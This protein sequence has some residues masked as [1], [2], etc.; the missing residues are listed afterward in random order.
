MWV[1]WLDTGAVRSGLSRA[2]W[3]AEVEDITAWAADNRPP[4][5]MHGL[6][7]G[8]WK[9]GILPRTRRRT[10]PWETAG[11]STASPTYR[12]ITL[13][14]R[15]PTLYSAF[16]RSA[17]YRLLARINIFLMRGLRKEH[18]RLPTYKMA[19][20]GWCAWFREGREVRLLPATR[21]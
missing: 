20:A 12:Q 9:W 1:P 10:A 2:S 18:E 7:G 5:P 13:P 6:T 3:K 17:L 4:Y 15:S 16:Y 8:D 21:L 14:R 19:G 11:P